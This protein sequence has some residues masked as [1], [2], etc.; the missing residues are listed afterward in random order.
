[1]RLSRCVLLLVLGQLISPAIGQVKFVTSDTDALTRTTI[2]FEE[3]DVAVELAESTWEAYF[4]GRL[5]RRDGTP[6][7]REEILLPLDRTKAQVARLRE[8]LDAARSVTGAWTPDQEDIAIVVTE[9]YWNLVLEESRRYVQVLREE[10]A[11]EGTALTYNAAAQ[12]LRDSRDELADVVF[13][14]IESAKLEDRDVAWEAWADFA[15]A[16]LDVRDGDELES[17]L[18]DFLRAARIVQIENDTGQKFEYRPEKG[19]IRRSKIRR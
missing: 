15:D 12:R 13:K 3:L 16:S 4:A 11:T 17:Q 7:S 18:D 14:W 2:L 6:L 10:Q 5:K 1:M 9:V 8:R 19:S